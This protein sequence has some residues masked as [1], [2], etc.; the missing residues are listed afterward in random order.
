MGEDLG[1]SAGAAKTQSA[2]TLPPFLL[3]IGCR[4]SRKNSKNEIRFF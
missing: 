3:E 2:L 4:F 1:A